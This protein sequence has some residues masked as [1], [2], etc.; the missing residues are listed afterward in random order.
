MMA[1]AMLQFTFWVAACFEAHHLQKVARERAADAARMPSL[2]CLLD[3]E[4]LPP[5]GITHDP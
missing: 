5:E 1:A 4:R 3:A 2:A